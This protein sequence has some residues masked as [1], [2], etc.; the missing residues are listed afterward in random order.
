MLHVCG[1]TVMMMII[2]Y[3]YTYCLP[4]QGGGGG[5]ENWGKPETSLEAADRG[6]GIMISLAGSNQDQ[7]E[8]QSKTKL[9]RVCKIQSGANFA[10][11][12]YL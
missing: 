8:A 10:A 9:L 12:P 5:G 6:K 2:L 4:H 1:L 11:Q 3:I 7:P